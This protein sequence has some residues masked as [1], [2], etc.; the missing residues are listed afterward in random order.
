MTLFSFLL[1]GLAVTFAEK[2]AKKGL[3][4]AEFAVAYYKEVGIGGQ[5]DLEAAQRWYRKVDPRLSSIDNTQKF[6][7]LL[8]HDVS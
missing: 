6:T 3:P 7:D 2:A 8:L 4:T 1:Q 5:K